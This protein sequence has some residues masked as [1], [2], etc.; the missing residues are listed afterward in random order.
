M[1][2][3]AHP[4]THRQAKWCTNAVI[5]VFSSCTHNRY[6]YAHRNRID[7]FPARVCYVQAAD[8]IS[9]DVNEL[10]SILAEVCV[11]MPW[12][13]RLHGCLLC[14]CSCVD[15]RMGCPRGPVWLIIEMNGEIMNQSRHFSR[16]N[17][18]AHWKYKK[19]DWGKIRSECYLKLLQKLERLHCVTF[20]TNQAL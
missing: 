6:Q 10:F 15:A 14:G 3:Q 13:L 7:S 8:Y 11:W 18:R 16:F 19:S 4:L 20:E 17:C 12:L 5:P 9:A 1:H 2:F